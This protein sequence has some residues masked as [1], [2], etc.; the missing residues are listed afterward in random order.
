MRICDPRVGIARD[1]HE[2]NDAEE[3]RPCRVPIE[4]VHVISPRKDRREQEGYQHSAKA[5]R[6]FGAFALR[7]C[8]AQRRQPVR[9]DRPAPAMTGVVIRSPSVGDALPQSTNPHLPTPSGG[10]GSISR[11]FEQAAVVSSPSVGPSWRI[12]S[13]SA[14]ERGSRQVRKVPR[15]GLA[16]FAEPDNLSLSS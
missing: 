1:G 11:L 3:Q 15:R 8:D 14:L 6:G 13:M 10:L 5:S 12:L 4:P 9:L 7:Y 2:P 16:P